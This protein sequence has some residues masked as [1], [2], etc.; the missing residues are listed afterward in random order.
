MGHAR[1]V[2]MTR[3]DRR[4]VPTFD[5]RPSALSSVLDPEGV[6]SRPAGP[7]RVTGGNRVGAYHGAGGWGFAECSHN[8]LRN[9]ERGS[10]W[11]LH[12]H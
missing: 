8:Q 1:D 7:A 11:E 9:R 6:L 2:A 4:P 5:H 12:E 10:E 3:S